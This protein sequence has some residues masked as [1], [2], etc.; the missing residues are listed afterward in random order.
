MIYAL[1]DELSGSTV[2][3]YYIRNV[4]G[5]GYPYTI[6]GTLMRHGM[7]R[8]S[9]VSEHGNNV[10]IPIASITDI[11]SGPLGKRKR[12]SRK[13]LRSR[14]DE[15]ME[16]GYNNTISPVKQGLNRN[17]YDANKNDYIKKREKPN[18]SEKVK[19]NVREGEKMKTEETE[20]RIEETAKDCVEGR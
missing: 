11:T 15:S 13:S 8:V 2:V 16:G 18:G 12:K 3:I 17:I 6:S 1:L 5:H 10:K 4:R 7:R 19:R 14:G 9:I 20:N